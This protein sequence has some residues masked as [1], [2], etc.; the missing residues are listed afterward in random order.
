MISMTKFRTEDLFGGQ[1]EAYARSTDKPTSHS[2]ADS[3]KLTDIEQLV[4]D[5]ISAG[6]ISGMTKDEIH[7]ASLKLGHRHERDSIGPRLA[8][9]ERKGRIVAI[10]ERRARSGRAQ[11]VYLDNKRISPVTY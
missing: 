3:V 5:I 8:P 9:L 10:G 11:T 1:T 6:P 2:A 7:A 4:F